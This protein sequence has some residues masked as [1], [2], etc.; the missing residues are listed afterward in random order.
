[1]ACIANWEALRKLVKKFDKRA[2]AEPLSNVLLPLLYASSI[3]SLVTDDPF[4]TLKALVVGKH[5]ETA[6]SGD[7]SRLGL[8]AEADALHGEAKAALIG[9]DALALAHSPT[10]ERQEG[11]GGEGRALMPVHGEGLAQGVQ[12]EGGNVT[13]T[14]RLPQV[15][16]PVRREAKRLSGRVNTPRPTARR[17]RAELITK[18]AACGGG[19]TAST[20]P[21]TCC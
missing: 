4:E 15:A 17:V 20:C 12:G 10:E 5:P 11:V 18:R 21:L 9:V 19:S 3:T 13:A 16:T 1:M 14:I 6:T 8:L 2:Q 7:Q